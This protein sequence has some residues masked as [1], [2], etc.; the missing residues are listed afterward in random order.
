MAYLID[1]PTFEDIRGNLTVI[2]KIL[3]FEIKRS[4]FI[5]NVS[6]ERGGHRHKKT[7]QAFICVGGSCEIYI[8]NG[9]KENKII[10]DRPNKCLIVEAEDW[11]TMDKFSS[12]S[13]L[14]VLASEYYA[15]DDYIDEAYK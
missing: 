15:R 11:H 2:E 7:T 13:T 9:T 5:Y 1:L 10:L 4:Y 3:P 14:L 12:G 6:Q 8:N